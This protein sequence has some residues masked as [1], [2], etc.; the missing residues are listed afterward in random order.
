[1]KVTIEDVRR[2]NPEAKVHTY[3]A[4]RQLVRNLR[5]DGVTVVLA[6]GVFDIVHFGHV[7]YLRASLAVDPRNTVVIVGVENDETVRRNKGVTRPINSQGERMGMLS[8]FLSVGLIFAYETVPDYKNP[9][10]YLKRYKEL[11]PSAVAVPT[12]DP[13]LALKRWQARQA[14]TTVAPLNYRFENSTTVMLKR[15]G[16]QE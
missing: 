10:D 4:M 15:L 3:G 11:C 9:H 16:Y 1:M 6:Q 14:D 13:H 12:W 8:E 2:L 5:L 7:G